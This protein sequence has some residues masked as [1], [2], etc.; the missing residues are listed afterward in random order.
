MLME[1]PKTQAQLRHE[2]FE[3]HAQRARELGDKALHDIDEVL[4]ESQLAQ[5]WFGPKDGIPIT[6]EDTLASPIGYYQPPES[7]YD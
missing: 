2:E 4:A 5:Q 1:K 6:D 7:I 3:R